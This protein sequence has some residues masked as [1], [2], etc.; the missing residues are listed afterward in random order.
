MALKGTLSNR[1]FSK[2]AKM[3]GNK[4][5]LFSLQKMKKY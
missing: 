3:K 5:W 2:K 1:L 4:K